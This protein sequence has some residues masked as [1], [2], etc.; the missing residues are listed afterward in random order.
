M[1]L[2]IIAAAT[3]LAVLTAGCNKEPAPADLNASNELNDS[4]TTVATSE[5]GPAL[6]N[7]DFANAIAGGGRFEIDSAALVASKATSADLKALAA[8]I[9][10]D[11]KKAGEDLKAAATAS[12]P[13]F[14]PL[15]S[16]N[17]KQEADLEALKAA[18]GNFDSLYV[19]Q[20]ITA[21]QEAVQILSD[22]AAGGTSPQLREFASNVLPTVRGHL[23]KLNALPK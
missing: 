12:S 19:T 5:A 15:A 1:R 9:A 11:H 21:H 10:S 13:S 20:Q 3:S 8:M 18:S 6:G 4:G 7:A 22:Y 23:D 14:T 17:A 2:L 16:L